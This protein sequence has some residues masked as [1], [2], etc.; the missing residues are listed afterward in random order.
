[1]NRTFYYVVLNDWA[2]NGCETGINV[3]GVATTLDEAKNIFNDY[4]KEEKEMVERRDWIVFEDCD[5]IFDAG[6]DGRYIDEH[7]HVCIERA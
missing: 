5:T 3:I 7:T 1:M 2:F 4:V 6:K